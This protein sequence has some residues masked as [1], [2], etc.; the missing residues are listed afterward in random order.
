MFT[1]DQIKMAS[2]ARGAEMIESNMAE[3]DKW[4]I[5]GLLAIF[6]KQTSDEQWA[7]ST[8]HHNK[9]GFT[10]PDSYLMSKFAKQVK[11][12]EGTPPQ[13]RRYPTPLSPRQREITRE[14]MPKYAGQLAR[15]VRARVG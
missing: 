2:L 5:R 3:S 11:S 15:I 8:Q 7:C 6:D 1:S 13:D 9:V 10:G 14:R 12:W 4:L